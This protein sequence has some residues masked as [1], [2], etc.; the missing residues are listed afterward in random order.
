MKTGCVVPTVSRST[1]AALAAIGLAGSVAGCGVIPKDGPYANDVRAGAEVT[2]KPAGEPIAYAFVSLSPL[3]LKITNATTTSLSPAF[4]SFTASRQPAQV[5]IAPGD[6]VSLTIY[7]AT[8]G[9]LFLSGDNAG[10]NGN[11]VQVPTQQVDTSGYIDVPYAGRVRVAGQTS[12]EVGREIAK[13]IATRAIEPQVVVSVTDR[14]GNDVAVL[15]EIFSPAFPGRFSLDPGGIRLLPAIAKAGGPK[16]PPYETLVTVQRGSQTEQAIMTNI[17]R[18]PSQNIQLR[19]GDSVY[20]SREPK[21]FLTLGATPS[22]GAV[23]GINNRRFVFDNDNI[24]LA[25]ALA[26][27]GGLDDQRADPTAV[28]IYRRESKRTLAE[29][30]VDTSAYREDFVPTI[31]TVDFSQPDGLFMS[32]SFFMRDRDVIYVAN[33]RVTDTNK[34]LNIFGQTTRSFYE[35]SFGAGSASVLGGAAGAVR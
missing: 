16:Y 26:K 1:L 14:R 3:S 17:L 31:F 2:V 6:S 22:P 33:S 23:G 18:N 9:G 35:V 30:G 28:F 10:R 15:G 32:N 4:R 34:I 24:T 29:M 8:T 7:E 11:Y 5:R 12:E 25:E 20:L 21:I 19:P 27:S 13:K